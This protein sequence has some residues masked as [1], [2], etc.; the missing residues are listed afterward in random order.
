[1]SRGRDWSSNAPIPSLVP[2]ASSLHHLGLSGSPLTNIKSAV[3]ERGLLG[4]S[5]HLYCSCHLANSKGFFRALCQ[6]M[7]T[8]TKYRS[9]QIIINLRYKSSSCSR[10]RWG[11][12]SELHLGS[13]L[14]VICKILQ[15]LHDASIC[16]QIVIRLPNTN[17]IPATY[18]TL[19]QAPGRRESRLFGVLPVC[20]D[21]V[22]WGSVLVSPGRHQGEVR[23]GTLVRLGGRWRRVR[24][25]RALGLSLALSLY[26]FLWWHGSH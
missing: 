7:G 4:V 26:I 24:L 23:L 15:R 14:S 13:R 19:A 5:R 18:Q 8:K 6:K 3:A 25:Y 10:T 1:M 20:G 12:A 2:L 11:T 16:S 17:C 22:R 21:P 9:L